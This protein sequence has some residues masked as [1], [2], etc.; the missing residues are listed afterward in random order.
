MLFKF[1]CPG[2]WNIY[3]FIYLFKASMKTLIMPIFLKFD[4]F[5]SSIPIGGR[6]HKAVSV[7]T[8][9]FLNAFF[10]DFFIE[11]LAT[12]GNPLIQRH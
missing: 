10:I 3:L 8:K 4:V 1:F 6:I 7:V 12:L 9:E 11:F 5:S 2:T